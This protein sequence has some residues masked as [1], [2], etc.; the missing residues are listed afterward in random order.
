M[1]LFSG[2]RPSTLGIVDGQL[3]PVRAGTQNTV[4]SHADNAYS[5]IAPFSASPNPAE[6]FKRLKTLV[7]ASPGARVITQ[8]ERYV[9]AEFATPTLG[10]VDDVEFLLD[11]KAQLIHVRS[12]SR[13]GIKDFG[14]NRKRLESL[15]Q[16][17]HPSATSFTAS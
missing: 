9:H 5:K 14:V 11:S 3:Q 4:S 6:T 17:L 1:G 16:R 8:D 12:G 15:R 7:A 13:L 2:K 10:F